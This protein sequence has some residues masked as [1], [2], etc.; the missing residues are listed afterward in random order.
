MGS[1][2]LVFGA[3]GQT[4]Q[5]F[6]RLLL[7][8][9][10]AVRAVARHPGKLSIAHPQL[11]IS[12][13]S[14][15]EELALHDLLQSVDAVTLMLGDA[16]QQRQ[17]KINTGFVRRL[18]P[19]MREQKVTRLLYQAG[20]FTRP[21]KQKLP[22]SLWLLRNTIVRWGGLIGQHEDNEAVIEYLVE[23]AGD[24]AW[25][26]HRAAIGSDGPTKGTLQRSRTRL[27]I[28][29]F[30]DCAEYS[31]RLLHDESAVHSCDLSCYSRYL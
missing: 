26:V 20:A 19:A 31:Y 16:T 2:F 25:A 8:E 29:T 30:R 23:E 27:S 13:G 3:T 24:I 10:H 12:R 17:S 7:A 6:V 4:G 11:E 22:I 5:H 14:I 28:G 15:T 1:T 21:Y 9:G 18:V